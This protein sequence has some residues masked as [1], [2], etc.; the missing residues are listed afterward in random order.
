MQEV[1]K[2]YGTTYLQS[3]F[4]PLDAPPWDCETLMET[5]QLYARSRESRRAAE[6]AAYDG[7]S[8]RIETKI[9]LLNG[10]E[11]TLT[12]HTST[13]ARG[14]GRTYLCLGVGSYTPLY[15][16]L[17]TEDEAVER[18]KL[19]DTLLRTLSFVADEGVTIPVAAIESLTY[20]R[21]RDG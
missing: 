21:G 8:I 19:A 17:E 18:F 2:P 7:P 16:R 10:K 20:V 14:A 6:T 15:W 5:A 1:K 9:R 4:P 13:R 3:V 11:Y 12:R